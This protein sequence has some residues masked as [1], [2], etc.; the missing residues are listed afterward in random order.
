MWSKCVTLAWRKRTQLTNTVKSTEN[1]LQ[2]N[3]KFD[4][5]SNP[6]LLVSFILIIQIVK[7]MPPEAIERGVFTRASDVWSFG[8][9]LWE[10]YAAAKP[11][12]DLPMAQVALGVVARGLRL[13][14][15]AE[16]RQCHSFSFFSPQNNQNDVPMR[17]GDWR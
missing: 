12:A 9:V 4:I 14:M 5:K 16:H 17:C 1:W 8:V 3:N 2:V 10:L 13:G 7:W 6:F 15:A 11:F